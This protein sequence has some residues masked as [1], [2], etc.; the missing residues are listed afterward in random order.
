[1]ISWPLVTRCRA[2][3][4]NHLRADVASIGADKGPASTRVRSRMIDA[5]KRQDRHED[6]L[7]NDSSEA[8][9]ARSRLE[10]RSYGDA[11]VSEF[12]G[13]LPEQRMPCYC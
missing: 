13:R 10:L 7:L 9:H 5:R 11:I 6:S 1:M 2:A 3:R 8:E 4:L 12:D